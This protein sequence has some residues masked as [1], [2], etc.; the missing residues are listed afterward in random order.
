MGMVGADVRCTHHGV[1]DIFP[2]V[3][4]V[5]EKG[6]FVAGNIPGNP[7]PDFFRTGFVNGRAD[8]RLLRRSCL[9]RWE[10]VKLPFSVLGA[11]ERL[12][13]RPCI[14]SVVGKF[15]SKRCPREGYIS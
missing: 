14:S 12:F 8:G 13:R 1:T 9:R 6:T 3:G 7:S 5:V 2:C 11:S 10:E 15:G 4:S